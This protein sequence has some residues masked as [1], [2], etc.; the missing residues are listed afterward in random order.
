M[1]LRKVKCAP[2]GEM[3]SQRYISLPLVY[4]TYI[5]LDPCKEGQ[6]EHSISSSN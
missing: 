2:H 5:Q 4:Q 3:L 1:V 6:R